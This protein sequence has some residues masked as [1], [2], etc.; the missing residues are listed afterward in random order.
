M[1]GSFLIMTV[2]YTRKVYLLID[3]MPN[4]AQGNN[5][6]RNKSFYQLNCLFT[7]IH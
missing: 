3:K 1:E 7:H 5:T 6:L 2:I 4:Q